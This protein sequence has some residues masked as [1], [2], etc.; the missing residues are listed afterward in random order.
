MDSPLTDRGQLQLSRRK[1]R[2]RSVVLVVVGTV[3]LMP[4]VAGI[5]L[6]DGSIGGI[7][8]PLLYVFVIWA[9]LV[10]GA[11]LLGRP[12]LDTEQSPSSTETHSPDN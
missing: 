10:A 11:A 5:S 4:P 3:V 1:V 6:T 12:L 9:A 2:D 7:P 8:S